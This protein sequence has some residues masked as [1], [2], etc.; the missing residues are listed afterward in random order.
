MKSNPTKFVGTNGFRLSGL[1]AHIVDMIY[2][3]AHLTSSNKTFKLEIHSRYLQKLNQNRNQNKKQ[4][5]K[6]QN[7]N[8]QTLGEVHT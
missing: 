7:E 3:A 8:G 1:K 2:T 6:N 4:P 5:R